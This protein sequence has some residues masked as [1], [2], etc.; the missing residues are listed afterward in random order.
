MAEIKLAFVNS[1]HRKW[2][3]QFRRTAVA[4]KIPEHNGAA[5]FIKTRSSTRRRCSHCRV[6]QGIASRI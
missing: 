1:Y 5:S 2:R 6:L 4:S 3:H